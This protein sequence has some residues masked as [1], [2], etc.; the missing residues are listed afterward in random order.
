VSRPASRRGP[1][2][3]PCLIGR[4]RAVGTVYKARSKVQAM[5]QETLREL[6]EVEAV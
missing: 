1:R 3:R 6:Q 4:S 5:L 2:R